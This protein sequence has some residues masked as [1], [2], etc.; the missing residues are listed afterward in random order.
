[1]RERV[2]VF[3]GGMGALLEVLEPGP[4]GRAEPVFYGT[5]RD[6]L[7]SDWFRVGSDLSGAML[8][9]GHRCRGQEAATQ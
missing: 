9:Y 1:M 2:L 7:T 4:E 3:L 5:D 8:K 6:R